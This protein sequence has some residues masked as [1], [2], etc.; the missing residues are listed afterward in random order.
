MLIDRSSHH[1]HR[2]PEL[3]SSGFTL[4][5]ILV[6][7]T[8]LGILA[9]VTV[10]TLDFAIENS[11]MSSAARALQAAL[12]GARDRASHA[13]EPRGI[14]LYYE[15]V[16][17]RLMVR[18]LSYLEVVD[19]E[20]AGSIEVRR[21]ASSGPPWGDPIVLIG[22]GTNWPALYDRGLLTE[23]STIRL[24]SWWY[25]I[26]SGTLS[27]SIMSDRLRITPAFRDATGTS[28]DISAGT[29]ANG[30]HE[31]SLSPVEMADED[32]IV[33]P[34]GVYIDLS[35]LVDNAIVPVAW[36][37]S[38][39][40]GQIDIMFSPLGT[41]E[42]PLSIHGLLHLPLVE[43]EDVTEGLTFGDEDK[44]GN[45][46]LVTVFTQTGQVTSPPIFVDATGSDPF[47]LVISGVTE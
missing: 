42:G 23:N 34:D 44:E 1:S 39:A 20:T 32:A 11:R 26:E 29:V 33:F 37:L 47:Q 17:G 28:S 13:Q 5:E 3:R 21:E 15:T 16:E 31:I 18:S 46:A 27:T 14:R 12:E 36:D 41:V 40:T 2:D 7:I 10:T 19:N 6:V 22:T 4:I 24:N 43:V 9:A 35:V 38:A 8:I 25:R 30:D 45:E